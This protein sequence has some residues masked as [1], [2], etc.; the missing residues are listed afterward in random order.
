MRDQPFQP[1]PI[2]FPVALD[3]HVDGDVQDEAVAPQSGWGWLEFFVLVQVL[4]GVLLFIPGSQAYRIYIRAFPFVTSLVALGV[5]MRSSGAD[6]GAPGAR[7]IVASLALMVA[8][9]VHPSTWLMSGTA[10]IVFQLS[11]AAPVFWTARN[12]LTAERLERVLVLVFCANFI[13]AAVGLLQVYY[14]QTFMPPE[15]SRLALRFNADIV[16]SLTYIGADGREIVR[17]PGLSDIPGGAAISATI[18]ALL[19]FAFATRAEGS[20]QRRLLFLAASMIGLTVVYLTQVRSMLVMICLCMMAAAAVRLRYGRIAHT[21]WIASAAAVVVIASFSWAVAVGG[22]SIVDRFQSMLD[23]GVVQSYQDN[24]GIFL[25]YTFQELLFEYPFGAGLGRWG[26]MSAYFGEPTNWQFPPLWAEIQLT[27]WLY[28]GGVLLWAFYAGAIGSATYHTYRIAGLS[29]THLS[30]LAT[31]VLTVQVLII[32]LCF[33]GPVFN[34]QTGIVFWLL[35]ASVFGAHR[36]AVM[37]EQLDID[38]EETAAED[39]VP[40]EVPR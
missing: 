36:T 31:M 37:S 23:V 13:S 6:S 14:P 12:W 33:T 21:A 11:I 4:W 22:D 30:D 32:G 3:P 24:R 35:S 17:P 27:G 1:S 40:A 15:F 18:T 34:T 8:S 25:S 19:G 5:C 10:Q 39:G 9:L 2:V 28:D 26:M 16:G 7:W 20:H 38:A 29:E